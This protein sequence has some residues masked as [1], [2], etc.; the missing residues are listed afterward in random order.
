MYGF[1]NLYYDRH[2]NSLTVWDIN[3]EGKT[4]RKKI[5]PTIDYYVHDEN[6]DSG[7]TDIWGTPV[8]QQVSRSVFA[9]RKAI[10]LGNMKTCEANIDQEIKYLQKKYA[11]KHIDTDMDHYQ[12]CTIDIEVEIGDDP[13]PFDQFVEECACPV[14]LITVH[15]SK[16]NTTHTWGNKPYNGN[17]LDKDPN[18]TYHYIPDEKAMLESFINHFRRRN[19]DVI[20]GWNSKCF[21]MRYLIDRTEVLN[22]DL[23]FSP[24]NIY[25]EAYDSIKFADGHEIKLKYYKIAG[26]SQLDGLQLYKNFTFTKEVSYKLGYIGQRVCNEGKV[27][28]DDSINKIYETNWDLFVEYNIQDVVLV[29]KIETEK[30]FIQLTIQ[31]CTQAMIPFENVFSSIKVIT[32]YMLN[33]LHQYGLVMP[34]IERGHKEKYP[35]AYVKA[36]RGVYRYLIS[37]DFASL[38]PTIIRMFNISPETL[39]EFPDEEDIPNLIKTPASK[40]YECDTPKGHFAVEGIYYKKDKQGILPKIVETIYF[41]RVDFKD[42][43]KC[44]FGIANKYSVEQIAT[45]QHWSLDKAKKI[46]DEVISEGYSEAYYD[47]QQQIRKILI[48]SMYGV[49]GN[50]FF[51]FYN[52]KNAMAITIAGRD[53]IEYVSNNINKYFR[54]KWHLTFWKYFPEYAHLKG[55]LKPIVKDMIPVIDTDSNYVCL[56]EVITGL[57]LTF[58]TN[59]EY[60]LWADRF[61]TVFMKPFF[62]KILELYAKKYNAVNL[63]DFKRE[64]IVTSKLVLKKK[65]YADIVIENEGKVYPEPKLSITGIDMVKTTMPSL[66]KDSS[67]A[68]LKSMLVDFD[69]DKIVDMLREYKVEFMKADIFNISANRTVGNYD[70][71][72]ESLET[73]ITNGEVFFK[74]K[75]PQ[76]NKASILYNFLIKKKKLMYPFIGNGSQVKVVYVNPNN[77]LQT[78]VIAY[79]GD[80]PAEFKEYFRVDYEVQWYKNFIKLIEDFYEAFGWGDVFLEKTNLEEFVVF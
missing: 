9:M 14:N 67:K 79:V 22:V 19:V 56:D 21:D 71:W 28:L 76:Q 45:N 26:I 16:N 65:K 54:E 8:K 63:H 40:L 24:L 15:Y 1:K 37:Y 58:K 33:Y 35:G 49:L 2:T 57:G 27:A 30:K 11:N 69:R 73:Y 46:Y 55:E 64:K 31:L 34:D 29:T 5:K 4:V 10:Q 43:A 20:T 32:G 70:K 39:V 60:R 25:E 44:A 41:E 53:V 7:L 62:D 47:S 18:W 6:S 61:D 75:T 78:E 36:V 50:R 3:D 72:A 13:K 51:S 12:V 48:N 74:S 52:I 77:I 42:K 66:F 68:I 38:Y 17:Y 80:Y 59:E 23:S